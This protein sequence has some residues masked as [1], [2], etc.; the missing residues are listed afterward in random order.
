M[1]ILPMKKQA[2]R[3]CHLEVTEVIMDQ[4]RV[5]TCKF[6]LSAFKGLQG[7]SGMSPLCNDWEQKPCPD[8][9]VLQLTT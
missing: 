4:A 7:F 6:T 1:P 5:W 9:S 8:H 2:R 3:D